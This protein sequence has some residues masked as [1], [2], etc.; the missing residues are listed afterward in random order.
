MR[1]VIQEGT[2]GRNVTI[3]GSQQEG[4]GAIR[5]VSIRID[6]RSEEFDDERR[7]A[8]MRGSQ[9]FIEPRVSVAHLVEALPQDGYAWKPSP[10]L[11]R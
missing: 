2:H 7:L 1:A 10:L 11:H 5:I 6:A 8:A 4:R 9:E 3:P